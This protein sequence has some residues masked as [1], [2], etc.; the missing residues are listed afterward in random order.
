MAEFFDVFL[1]FF[2]KQ[3]KRSVHKQTRAVSSITERDIFVSLPKLL[4]QRSNPP[5]TNREQRKKLISSKLD[6]GNLKD[7]IMLKILHLF[8]LLTIKKTVM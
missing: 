5:Q 8:R 1:V 4:P 2:L 7:E 3:P 6:A